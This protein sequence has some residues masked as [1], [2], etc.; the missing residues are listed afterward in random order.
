[1]NPTHPKPGFSDYQHMAGRFSLRLLSTSPFQPDIIPFHPN[2]FLY[3]CLK[4]R[5]S[6]WKHNWA[7]SLSVP[8]PSPFTP[9]LSPEDANSKTDLQPGP[10]SWPLSLLLVDDSIVAGTVTWCPISTSHPP[11]HRSILH[12]AVTFMLL[13][14][15]NHMMSFCYLKSSRGFPLYGE[16]GH[17]FLPAFPQKPTLLVP[18]LSH[19]FC[20][21]PK[22]SLVC[23]SCLCAH[24]LA[25]CLPSPNRL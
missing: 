2:I 13:K 17:R 21:L 23:D 3:I 1:M 16:Y 19:P 12:K 25:Y 24:L 11:T 18:V 15:I 6:F 22:I 10:C 4:D 14:D 20:F 9:P 5:N 7:S 8:K